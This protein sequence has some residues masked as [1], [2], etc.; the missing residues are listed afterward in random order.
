MFNVR[1][2]K[3]LPG[4]RVSD[5]RDDVLGLHVAPNGF[6]RRSAADFSSYGLDLDPR[7]WFLDYPPHTSDRFATNPYL[8]GD[9]GGQIG[10]AGQYLNDWS[11]E[12]RAAHSKC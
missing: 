10:Q 5:P 3:F 7:R 11:S 9:L 4:F 2:A 1:D 12:R 8:N 6:T